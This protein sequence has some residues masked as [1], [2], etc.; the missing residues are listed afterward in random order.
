VRIVTKPKF[1]AAGL[2]ICLVAAAP[3]R[4]QVTLDVSKI[5]CREFLHD[6][7]TVPDNIAYWLSGYYNGKRGSTVFDVN[8]LG[9]YVR[10]VE[11]YCLRHQDIT[12]MKAAEILIGAGK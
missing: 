7:I 6:T 12:V 5:T 4:A 3:A 9:D 10:K 11:D 1:I 8:G 2:F